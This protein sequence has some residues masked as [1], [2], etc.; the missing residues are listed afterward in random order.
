MNF[1]INTSFLDYRTA[2]EF[3]KPPSDVK[4]AVVP[5]V[6]AIRGGLSF[7]GLMKQRAG[8]TVSIDNIIFISLFELFELVEHVFSPFWG[9][10]DHFWVFHK[11]LKNEHFR[12][13]EE[14]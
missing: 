8:C 1:L 7:R 12:I 2:Y 11:L 6:E 5:N 10:F 9:V 3:P 4:D 14:W 13:V